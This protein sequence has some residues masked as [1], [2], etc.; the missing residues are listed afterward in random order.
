MKHFKKISIFVLAFVLCLSA[1]LSTPLAANADETAKNYYL[2]YVPSL[3]EWRV[4]TGS[5]VD[6]GYHEGLSI[7]Q[8][9]IKDGDTIV[10]DDPTNVGLNL[11]VNVALGS[12]FVVH[13][14]NIVVT[15]NGIGDFYAL[16]D[17]VSAINADVTNAYVYDS[18]I[19]NFNKNV[20]KL[21]LLSEKNDLLSATIVVVGTLDHVIAS[22]KSYKHF[23]FYDFKENTFYIKDGSLKTDA[24]NYSSSPSGT[25]QTPGADPSD[26]GDEYDEVPKTADIRFSPLLLACIAAICFIGSYKLK[27]NR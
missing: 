13:G 6:D 20:S 25:P 19:V 10:I 26:P 22:G 4:Q 24:S 3:N 5:W 15:A 12:L 27:K 16:N 1:F 7:M 14:N 9:F 23:E 18:G 11:Q 21:E 2:R 17:S 8:Q